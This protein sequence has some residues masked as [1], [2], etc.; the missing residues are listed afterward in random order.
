ME[1]RN[2]RRDS[3]LDLKRKSLTLTNLF[4]NDN[5]Q[6]HPEKSSRLSMTAYMES[7]CKENTDWKDYFQKKKKMCENHE[8]DS[9]SGSYIIRKADVEK[10]ITSE[11][12]T[13][14]EN[15]P[16]YC[17]MVNSVQRY[18]NAIEYLNKLKADVIDS[19]NKACKDIEINNKCLIEEMVAENLCD[20]CG[21]NCN[22]PCHKFEI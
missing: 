10:R 7:L 2:K 14:I 9:K 20:L 12:R 6:P 11:D 17:A 22:T 8:K 4:D 5:D 21:K 3:F 13:F 1:N 16:D 18:A 19:Y 15:R